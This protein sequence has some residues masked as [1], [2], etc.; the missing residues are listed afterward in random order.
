MKITIIAH[1]NSRHPRIE[2]DLL[3]DLHVHVNAPALEGKANRRIREMLAEYYN[4][5][6][7]KIILLSGNKN[8]K[9][10]F[11]II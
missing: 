1:V 10:L 4:T 7:N 5:K 2:E 6:N 8:K 9:K 3:G 11:E